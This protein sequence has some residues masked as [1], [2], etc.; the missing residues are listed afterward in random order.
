MYR[1]IE[2]FL[3]DWVY[4]SQATLSVL[5]ALSDA[6]LSQRVTPAGR[7]AGKLAWHIAQS[8]A[9]MGQETGL[10]VAGPA[11][12]DPIPAAAAEIAARYGEAAC[13]LSGAVKGQWTDELLLGEIPMYGE[14]WP[15]GKALSALIRHE[16]HHR[17]QLTVLMRQAGLVVPGVYG[18]AREEWAAMGMPAQD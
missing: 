12:A 18:P 1:H 16:A 2:D 4:E 5:R 11:E 17:G 13:A 3:A 9:G 7:S 10:T 15:R 8:V 14:M 6:A